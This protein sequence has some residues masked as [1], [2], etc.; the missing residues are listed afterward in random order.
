[1]DG[2]LSLWEPTV[3][4]EPYV[5]CKS[6][7]PPPEEVV[8][9]QTMTTHIGNKGRP[10]FKGGRTLNQLITLFMALLRFK[11]NAIRRRQQGDAWS[12]WCR[13]LQP[14]NLVTRGSTWAVA[15]PRGSSP[16][17][18]VDR[19]VKCVCV[20]TWRA[21]PWQADTRASPSERACAT[22]RPWPT[23]ACGLTVA[24]RQDA[25]S[26]RAS[27]SHNKGLRFKSRP[28]HELVLLVPADSA[29]NTLILS[30]PR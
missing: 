12:P 4:P 29:D 30:R 9:I 27:V 16:P 2:P 15:I 1:M 5:N 3:V 19:P 13:R 17:A 20:C 8:R 18:S 6:P 26:S 7:E 22:S 25:V 23:D 11:H 14:C 10:F 28:I 24:S 21:G